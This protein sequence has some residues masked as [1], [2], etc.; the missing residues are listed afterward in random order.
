[1]TDPSIVSPP[2]PAELPLAP[3]L[4]PAEPA[5]APPLTDARA[6]AIVR[7][8]AAAGLL[9]LLAILTIAAA[10]WNY[11]LLLRFT[12][13]RTTSLWMIL[14]TGITGTLCLGGV[15]RCLDALLDLQPP[16]HWSWRFLI[17]PAKR[18]LLVAQLFTTALALAA[19]ALFLLDRPI[20]TLFR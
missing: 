13:L 16:P 1:M 3:H 8:L 20:P 15:M 7:T 18:L 14:L 10:G 17:D 4:P 12:T 19:L 5:A 11:D 9:L 6:K 2:A